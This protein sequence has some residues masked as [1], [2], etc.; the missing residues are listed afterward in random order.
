M[1][2]LNHQNI[3]ETKLAKIKL[4]TGEVI[5]ESTKVAKEFIDHHEK[6]G[7]ELAEMSHRSNYQ[8]CKHIFE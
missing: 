3:R 7:K 6:V 2:T 1:R 4:P 5:E 8:L